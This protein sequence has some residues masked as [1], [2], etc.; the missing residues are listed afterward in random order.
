MRTI[1][2]D[3]IVILVL[4]ILSCNM[5][6]SILANSIN[7][8]EPVDRLFFDS[9]KNDNFDISLKEVSRSHN[10]STI[11][12]DIKKGTSVGGSIF[13]MCTL[14]KLTKE[15]G[16]K[17]FIIIEEGLDEIGYKYLIGFLNER[18]DY[19]LNELNKYKADL[20]KI[21]VIDVS[22][23]DEFCNKQ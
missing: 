23:F 9:I 7:N 8:M 6:T 3:Y 21:N 22:Q 19:S 5:P 11:Y 2:S 14:C 18:T 10:T 15:R 20:N 17:Y 13:I 16:Y 12:G 1:R 4:L